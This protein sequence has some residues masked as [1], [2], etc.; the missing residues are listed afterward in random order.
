MT[1]ICLT[2]DYEL[3]FGKNY[4]DYDEVLFSPTKML[5]DALAEEDVSATFFA[6]VF[7]A[8]RCREL[9][10]DDYYLKFSRQLVDMDRSGHDVQ[11]HVHPHWIRSDYKNGEW[12]FNPDY[13]RIHAFA[14]DQYSMESIVVDGIDYL[15]STIRVVNPQY[16]C[17]AYRAG[18]FAI[19]PHK[20][21]FRI[22]ADKGIKIDS[23]VAYRL[24]SNSKTNY[25]DFRKMKAK[26]WSISSN[27]TLFDKS[28]EDKSIYEIPI[29]ATRR[30][31]VKKIVSKVMRIG[32]DK[33]DLSP[34]R[35]TYINEE[36]KKAKIKII[37]DS[38]LGY[39]SFST[40]AYKAD[41]LY[42]QIK[43]YAKGSNEIDIAVIGHPKLVD[44]SYCKNLKQLI[45]LIKL[46]KTMNLCTV[47]EVYKRRRQNENSL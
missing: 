45:E 12:D 32:S 44:E 1:N 15:N 9:S 43:R 46:D 47:T 39:S 33:L 17:L 5:L 35:G 4:G 26:N 28:D 11:L 23:S 22:L 6:D 42:Q 34:K 21:L 8:L 19:Q 38:I 30:S 20:E 2:F 29:G 3:F 25:Y 10:I 41:Y 24:H 13:Y 14:N 27:S 37:W 18:G 7:S 36:S 40:D 16:R 31:L